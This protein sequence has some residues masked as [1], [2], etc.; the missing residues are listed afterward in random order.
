MVDH[1]VAGEATASPGRQG[2]PAITPPARPDGGRQTPNGLPALRKQIVAAALASGTGTPEDRQLEKVLAPLRTWAQAERQ[3]RMAGLAGV[4]DPSPADVRTPDRDRDDRA[5]VIALLAWFG[6]QLLDP[7]WIGEAGQRCRRLAERLDRDICAIDRLMGTQVDAILHH[8]RFQNL[9]ASWRG[10]GYLVRQ[11]DDTARMKVRL[12]DVTW[13]ELCR[14]QDRAIEFD[15]SQLFDKVYN[16]EFGMPGGEPYGVLIG[17]YEVC[18]RPMPGHRTDDIKGLRGIAAVAAAAFAPFIV[19]AA[20]PLLGLDSF[21][22]LTPTLNLNATFQH[23]DYDVW[24]GLREIED[25]RF[26]GVTAPRI[27]MRLPHVDGPGY[28]YGFRYREEVEGP[29]L[30]KYLWGPASFAFASIL[31]RAFADYGWFADIRG[32]PRD[33]LTGGLV[34]D[35]PV[36]C[37]GTDANGIAIKYSTDLSISE[38]QEMELSNLGFIPLSKCKDTD[39]SVFYSNQSIQL[40]KRYDKKIAN[41]NARLSTMLQYMMCVSRF[42]HYVKVIGRDRIGSFSTPEECQDFLY[43]WLMGY[44]TSNDNAP[45]SQKARFPLREANVQIREQLGRPGEYLATVYLRPH[46]QL[47]QVVAGFRLV[48]EVAPKSGQ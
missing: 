45:M 25:A 28:R 12:L 26:L 41:A 20:P 7:N 21:D 23:R 31:M 1:P 9:E 4:R 44:C 34:T 43:R 39:Y 40:P 29:T 16:T 24:R 47:D 2:T 15:Q 38:K 27:L 35:L 19:G 6:D 3:R 14:D 13:A 37:F 18:H 48:T 17:G 11:I 32:A 30:E 10:V 36:H 46:Y 8:Q 42:S 22:E 5:L 33:A